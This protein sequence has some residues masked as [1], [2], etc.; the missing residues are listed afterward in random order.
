MILVDTSILVDMLRKG[1]PA[2]GYISVVTL[3][4]FLRGVDEARRLE[5]KT[6]LEEAFNIAPIDNEVVLEYC[7]LYEGVRR[8]GLSVG[9]A[10]LLIAATAKANQLT[11]KTMDKDFERLREHG[12]N[13]EITQPTD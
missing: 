9:D 2:T 7:R 4:E 6:L 11:L 13:T 3:I 5:T 12:I 8:K 10:D 1:V